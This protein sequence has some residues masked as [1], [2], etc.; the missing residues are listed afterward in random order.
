MNKLKTMLGLP[1][2]GATGLATIV[3]AIPVVIGAFLVGSGVLLL[4][5]YLALLA[6]YFISLEF[7]LPETPPI[8]TDVAFAMIGK[9]VVLIAIGYLFA[10]VWDKTAIFC[11]RLFSLR[12]GNYPSQSVQQNAPADL[13]LNNNSQTAEH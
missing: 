2:K 10:F 5:L 9:G 1:S 11:R 13:G 3:M 12:R 4:L 7:P 8:E 6:L